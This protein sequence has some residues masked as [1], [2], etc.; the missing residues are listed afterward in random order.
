VFSSSKKTTRVIFPLKKH[1]SAIFC[2]S[3]DTNESI[4]S[5]NR[6][7]F[8][9]EIQ[10]PMFDCDVANDATTSQWRYADRSDDVTWARR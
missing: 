4:L 3:H 10:D 6:R 8:N 2:L 7:K 5:S 1:T 9:S